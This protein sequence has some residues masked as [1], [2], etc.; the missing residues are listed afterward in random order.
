[1]IKFKTGNILTDDSQAIVNTVNCV[2]VMG[3]G[4]ALQFKQAFPENFKRYKSACEQNR[5]AIGKMFITEY[6]DMFSKKYI[7]NFPTKDHWK[8]KSKQE[9]IESGLDD[10]IA[11][12]NKFNIKSVAIPP[13]GAGLG[14]LNWQLVRHV[15]IEKLSQMDELMV[16][17]YEPKVSHDVKYTMMNSKVPEMTKGRALLL[18]AIS[19]YCGQGYDC[20]KFEVQK[21][22]YLLQVSGVDLKLNYSAE[23]FGPYA[24]NL[25]YVLSHIEGHFISGFDDRITK[26]LITLNDKPMGDADKFLQSDKASLETLNRLKTLIEGYETPLSLEVLSTVHWVVKNEDFD[27]TDTVAIKRFIDYR[28]Q[29]KDAITMQFLVKAMTRLQSQDWV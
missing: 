21:L 16:N 8:G 3:K 28:H 27:V 17:V 11:N 15:I 29:H 18:K 26:S 14:G 22:A 4:L 6:D 9:Y 20:T 19:F 2:G 13:L 5:V 1:M 25:N 7:I 23:R 24:E 12:I 10:L